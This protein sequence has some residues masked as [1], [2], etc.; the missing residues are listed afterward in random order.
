MD[1]VIARMNPIRRGWVRSFAVGDSSRCFGCSKDWVEKKVRRHLRRARNRKGLGWQRWRRQWLYGTLRLFHNYRVSR[2]QPKALPV[3]EVPSPFTGTKQE[4]TVRDNRTLRLTW[5]G[6]ETWPRWNG[7]PISQSKE[8]DW[9][10]S[11]YSR[12]ACPRPYWGGGDATPERVNAPYSTYLSAGL[13][14][15]TGW[16]CFHTA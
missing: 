5:R 8:R 13:R 2:P 14:Y 12:R 10:P 15:T 11:T 16:R 4:S 9:K 6:L 3:R 7:E 1:R